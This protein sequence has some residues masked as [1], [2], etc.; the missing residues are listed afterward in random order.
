MATPAS[1]AQVDL[2]TTCTHRP[3]AAQV[4][5]FRP[6]TAPLLLEKTLGAA[7]QAN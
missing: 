1:S 6:H 4:L 2:E 3:V 5:N 7:L